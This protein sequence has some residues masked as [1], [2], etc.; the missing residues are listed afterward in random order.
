MQHVSGE[1]L[2]DLN[3]P[4]GTRKHFNNPGSSNENTGAAAP[5]LLNVGPPIGDLNLLSG[6]K[7]ANSASLGFGNTG[8]GNKNPSGSGFGQLKPSISGFADSGFGSI[9]SGD[10]GFSGIHSVES[11]FGNIHSEDLGFGGI[12]SGDAGFGSIHSV[13]SGFGSINA[14][15]SS[16][17]SIN[18]GDSGF[19]NIHS[20]DTGFSNIHSGDSGFGP[21]VSPDIHLD[22]NLGF[23]SHGGASGFSINQHEGIIPHHDIF[24]GQNEVQYGTPSI[25][26]GGKP[27]STGFSDFA[28]G[29]FGPVKD[30]T[31]LYGK[32]SHGGGYGSS[33][34]S[35]FGHHETSS[36][37]G[38]SY[39]NRPVFKP[40]HG[41]AI[42]GHSQ[43]SIPYGPAPAYGPPSKPYAGHALFI[44]LRQQYNRPSKGK[45]GKGNKGYFKKFMGMFGY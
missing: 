35:S 36:H 22:A 44:P 1:H 7:G 9:L 6:N 20:G 12:N 10:N 38:Q 15:D 27:F 14:G 13:D 26:G 43:G 3:L 37:T 24:E 5:N 19:G 32:P 40:I 18:S 25:N 33:G 39:G 23:G 30:D 11:G 21:P 34:A 2:Q 17:S 4:P 41:P 29:G 45:G 28:M 42:S 8:F 16:F 31:L